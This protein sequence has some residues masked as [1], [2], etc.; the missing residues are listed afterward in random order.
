MQNLFHVLRDPPYITRSTMQYHKLHRIWRRSRS[1]L[2]DL[3]QIGCN[4]SALSRVTKE[5][6][7]FSQ[8]SRN[9]LMSDH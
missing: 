8:A 7:F 3:R 9:I 5:E 1:F 4:L 2:R 6:I